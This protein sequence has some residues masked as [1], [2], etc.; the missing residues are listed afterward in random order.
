MTEAKKTSVIDGKEVKEEPGRLTKALGK[1][2][3]SASEAELDKYIE[4]APNAEEKKKR[5]AR[6]NLMKAHKKGHEAQGHEIAADLTRDGST[7]EG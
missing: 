6:V 2:A 5:V 4:N 1:P 7:K 3:M